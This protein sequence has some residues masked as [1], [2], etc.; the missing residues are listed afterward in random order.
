MQKIKPFF[1]F[2]LFNTIFFIILVFLLLIISFP[3][4]YSLIIAS[5]LLIVCY[6]SKDKYSFILI[7]CSFTF[8][9]ICFELILFFFK[10]PIYYRPFEMLATESIN[11]GGCF[12]SNHSMSF[13]MPYGDLYAMSKADKSIIENH[14]INFITDKYGFRNKNNFHDQEYILFGDSFIFGAST[15]QSDILSEVLTNNYNLKTYNAGFPGE[16]PAYIKKYNFFK[17]KYNNK[18]KSIFL[19]FEGNDFPCPVNIPNE[20]SLKQKL[21]KSFFYRI[22]F[23]V[24]QF[25]RELKVYRLFYNLT[26]RLTKKEQKVVVIKKIKNDNIG[27]YKEYMDVTKNDKQC[28]SWNYIKD[29]FV[30]IRNEIELIV[31]IPTK[32]RV[33]SNLIEPFNNKLPNEQWQFVETMSKEI[34]IKAINLT[35]PL[36][37]A[38]KELIKTNQY[39]YWRDDTHWNANGIKVAAEEIVKII[40][41]NKNN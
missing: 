10:A 36:I 15:D 34:N 39:T 26:S 6:F 16:I 4:N 13:E 23:Y 5:I 3:L 12:I 27:F 41:I 20:S 8:I 18:F 7:C 11:Y 21:K 22:F 37:T 35:E 30:K 9:I 40:K 32:Y 17:K 24:R 28:E 31:F 2:L 29:I 1:K 38:S 25:Y 19:I 14:N 33:Y